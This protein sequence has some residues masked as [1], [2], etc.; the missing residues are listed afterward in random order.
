MDATDDE[1]P[2]ALAPKLQYTV[3]GDKVKVRIRLVSNRKTVAEQML[4]AATADVPALAKTV[5]AAIVELAV[6]IK[7]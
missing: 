5:A 3:S 2:G 1:L 7:P 6:G 4:T